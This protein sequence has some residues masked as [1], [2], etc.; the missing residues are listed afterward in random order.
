MK[1]VNPDTGRIVLKHVTIPWRPNLSGAVRST[2]DKEGDR[3]I[4]V[5]LNPDMAEE[6]RGAGYN[7]KTWVPKNSDGD[8][9]AEP[10]NYIK[11]KLKYPDDPNFTSPFINVVK[12]RIVHELTK[13]TVSCIDN[14]KII[15]ID[16][17]ANPYHWRMPTGEEG[18]TP[19]ISEMY[20]VVED[21]SVFASE[22][23]AENGYTVSS[24]EMTDTGDPEE[25][26]FN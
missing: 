14:F 20:V 12:N 11:M 7:V 16:V 13:D 4:D 3:H 5:V 8:D 18:V 22:Y 25:I 17:S 23:S 15:S 21:R 26:P 10:V 19:Y 2:Y 6:L 9:P 24:E 1:Y